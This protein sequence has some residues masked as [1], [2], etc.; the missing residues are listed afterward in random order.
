MQAAPTTRHLYEMLQEEAPEPGVV[1]ILGIDTKLRFNLAGG[2]IIFDLQKSKISFNDVGARILF[3]GSVD[4]VQ[5]KPDNG[6][7]IFDI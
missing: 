3:D 4:T 6:R 7:L 2:R 1:T 5:F